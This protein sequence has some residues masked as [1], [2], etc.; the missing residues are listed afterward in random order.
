MPMRFPMATGA[1][2]AV[3]T[4]LLGCGQGVAPVAP[5]PTPG[6]K[7]YLANCVACHRLDGSGAPGMQ[8]PLAGTPVTVGD[9]GELLAWVMYGRRP[10]VLT[11]GTYGGLMPQFSYLR[12]A[13]LA[14]LLSHVRSNF[15]NHASAVTPAMVAAARAAQLH[16]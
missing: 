16:R 14:D 5:P 2:G 3:A 10:A 4:V 15:G 12:D 9:P 6:G 8:P 13:E 11:P 7:L 1:V